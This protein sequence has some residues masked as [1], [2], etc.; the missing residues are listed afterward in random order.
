MRLFHLSDL[1]IGKQFYG[2]SLLEDQE[3]ILQEILQLVEERKPDAVLLAGD[4]YDKS[5][6][7][8]EA[9]AVFDR[10]L[11][12]LAVQE[13]K[14]PVFLISGNHDSPERLAFAEKILERQQVY[15]AG[16]PP[17]K[18]E[19]FLKRITLQ[20]E[21]GPVDFWLLPFVKP[22]YVQGVFEEQRPE[23]YQ[24]A[25]EWILKR[26]KVDKNRRNVILAHQFFTSGGKKP[27]QSESEL[28]NVGGLD[29]VDAGCLESFEYAALGHI[30]RPQS[31]GRPGVRYCG[32]PLKYSVSE[33]DQEKT[34]TEVELKEKGTPPQIH[35]LPL[36][37]L[38]DVKALRGSLEEILA[39]EEGETCF[40]YVSVTLTDE[41]EPYQPKERL[42]AVFPRILE[43]RM[44]NSRFRN[45]E[46]K[47]EEE[48]EMA[49]PREVFSHFFVQMQGREMDREEREI[50]EE[51][52]QKAGE[53]EE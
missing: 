39:S 47:L 34:V 19:D 53:Q 11:S 7:A 41:Q 45:T 20:D 25:V 17:E 24:E 28:V 26:E 43:V 5:V 4:I 21:W 37:P 48:E 14:I 6:P 33:W 16:L 46:W 15:M 50:L 49:D 42:E 18:P 27:K 52:F 9:V 12:G 38:R 29:Q 22:G 51:I 44:D 10:F 13:P 36:T 2:Y 1:H 35:L 3:Y 8:A 30:H 32:T 40:D 23:T 31:M